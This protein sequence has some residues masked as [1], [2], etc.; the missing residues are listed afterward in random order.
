L[1]NLVDDIIDIAK[2]EAGELKIVKKDCNLSAL[3]S[4]LLS[5]SLETRKKFNKQH[6]SIE[7]RDSSGETD[8][9]M[10]TDPFRLRQVMIN[11]INNA[12]KFTDKGSIEFGFTIKDETDIEFF[13]KDTGPGMTREELD[14]IFERF[15]RARRSEERNIVGTGLGLA[16]SK[17]LV[18]LLG[19]EMWVNSTAGTGT[20]FVFAL[21]Y[22]KST[23]LPAE[24]ENSVQTDLEY[25]WSGKKILVAEDDMNSFKFLSELLRKT[26][27]EITHA[28]NGKKAVE[29]VNSVPDFDLVIMD[30]QLPYLDGLEV[31]RIIKSKYPSLP[32]IAQTA[33]AM[34]GDREKMKSAGCDDYVPKPLNPR[35]LMAVLNHYLTT[36]RVADGSSLTGNRSRLISN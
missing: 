17:N 32:V 23:I 2:I 1:L 27:A 21:P 33:Y 19:G 4:E 5:T 34:A 26:H 7:Y 22:L 9:Y 14:M 13:V 36:P 6:I 31:T 8:V 35:Q 18:Q 28:V 16:I 24:K 11:L 12:I 20:T 30:I 10:K 29:Y 3:C 25:N 15:K